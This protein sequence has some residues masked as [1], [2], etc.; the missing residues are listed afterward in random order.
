[1]A[2]LVTA[3]VREFWI[4]SQVTFVFS[5][6]D[7]SGSLGVSEDLRERSIDVSALGL[8]LPLP[9]RFAGLFRRVSN[10]QQGL[11]D[12]NPY[13]WL[14]LRETATLRLAWIVT[15]LLTGAWL[16]FFTLCLDRG[17]HVSSCFDGAGN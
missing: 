1:M 13:A 9:G 17:R 11:L 4:N 5:G 8:K 6:P 15:G 12:R 10:F 7:G 14:S 2:S 16:T 3:S